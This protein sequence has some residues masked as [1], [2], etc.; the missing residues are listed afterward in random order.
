MKSRAALIADRAKQS[1]G[2]KAVKAA[3]NYG[4]GRFTFLYRWR[5]QPLQPL[6]F[7]CCGGN[8][9]FVFVSRVAVTTAL[10]FS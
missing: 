3:N 2:A 9:R 8:N 5:W 1:A 4:D 6:V 7:F 10:V